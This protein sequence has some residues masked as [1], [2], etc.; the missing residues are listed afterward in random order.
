MPLKITPITGT[1]LG[2]VG[3][4]NIANIDLQIVTVGQIQ[5]VVDQIT[6]NNIAFQNRL[7]IIGITKVKMLAIKHYSG[8]KTKLKGFLTQIKLK[9]RHKKAKLPIIID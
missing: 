9:I 7:N 1:T 8:E 2:L 6:A 3:D 4:I 5:A